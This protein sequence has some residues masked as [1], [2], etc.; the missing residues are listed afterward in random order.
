MEIE[1]TIVNSL[2]EYVDSYDTNNRE[3]QSTESSTSVEENSAI[4][5]NNATTGGESDE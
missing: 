1:K 2:I 4:A 5:M 3:I